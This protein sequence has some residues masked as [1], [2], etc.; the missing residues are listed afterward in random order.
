MTAGRLVDAGSRFVGSALGPVFGTVAAVRKARALHPRGT[1]T[2]ATLRRISHPVTGVEWLDRSDDERVTVRFSRSA[3]L[4]APLPDVLG[5]A[6]AV[7]LGSGRRGDLLL[8]TAG[9]A[10]VLRHLLVPRLDPLG[11]A[12][13]C[14]IPYQSRRGAVMLGALP[15]GAGGLRL[16]YAR[17]VGAWHPFADLVLDAAAT[18]SGTS[19]AEPAADPAADAAAGPDDPALDLDPVLNPLPGL[20]LPT[21]L[22]RL[23]EPAYAWSR[24]QRHAAGDL[25]DAA[26]SL[27]ADPA[28]GADQAT[29]P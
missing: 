12:Y 21:A 9:R 28:S 24:R 6:I 27:D 2:A 3:G 17:P 14:L 22:A 1:V 29:Q 25:D 23:R 26:G 4:P 5:L 16:A 20:R 10:P 13:T 8:S 15:D 18:G 7:P 19:A 11:S